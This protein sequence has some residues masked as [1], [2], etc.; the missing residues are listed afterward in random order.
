MMDISGLATIPETPTRPSTTAPPSQHVLKRPPL[1]GA[2]V[3]VT[4]SLGNRVYLRQKEDAGTKVKHPICD[5]SVTLNHQ[6]VLDIYFFTTWPI[7]LMPVS[8]SPLSIAVCLQVVNSRTV[9]ESHGALGLLAVPIGVLRDQEAQR[10][11]DNNLQLNPV[12]MFVY[13]SVTNSTTV[14]KSQVSCSIFA[15]VYIRYKV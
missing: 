10:V 6:N 3:T 15:L 13:S 7:Y 11:S 9:P 4:D 5:S 14:K 8:M 1:E 12:I 2:Y